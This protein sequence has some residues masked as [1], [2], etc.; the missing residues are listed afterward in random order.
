MG[1]DIQ[2]FFTCAEDLIN[3]FSRVLTFQNGHRQR[4]TSYLFN[5]NAKYKILKK[6]TQRL[7]EAIKALEKKL[8]ENFLLFL[9]K[10]IWFNTGAA[11]ANGCMGTCPPKIQEI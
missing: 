2:E 4:I 10:T 7:A 3:K 1:P 8:K 11:R 5:V 6:E 9:E